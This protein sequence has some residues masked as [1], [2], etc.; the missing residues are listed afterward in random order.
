[1]KFSLFL[2]ILALAMCSV[3]Q[4]APKSVF[5][6]VIVGTWQDFTPDLWVKHMTLA[7]DAGI[8]GFVLNTAP[9]TE[10]GSACFSGRIKQQIGYA[11][12]ATQQLSGKST[13]K[14]FIAFDYLG[15]GKPWDASSVKQVLTTYAN[16]P[17]YF[18]YNNKAYVSTFEGTANIND[19]PGIKSAIT[20]GVFF[21]P[22]WTSLG[23]AGFASHL[24]VI[25]GAFSWDMWPN[26]AQDMTT[27]S[28]TAWKKA[29]GKKHYMMGI[30]PWFYTKMPAYN[31]AWVWRGD[32]MWHSR[33]DQI[34]QVQPDLVQIVTWND[35]GESHY[36]G[37]IFEPGVPQGAGTDA[38]AYVEDMPHDS[39]RNLLPYYIARYK[40]GAEPAVPTDKLQYWY[41]LTPSSVGNA[42]G[43]TGNN[44]QYQTVVNPNTVV[45]DK[46]F[47]TALVSAPAN[48]T[49]QI[50]NNTKTT[51]KAPKAGANHFSVP[52]NGQTGDVEIKIVC[53]GETLV[54]GTGEPIT[55]T[56]G[57]NGATNY[58]AWVGG[59]T[60]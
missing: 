34:S 31:K 52:F 39:W 22:D 2:S 38:E 23:P 53:N 7:R 33:W 16:H 43:V 28:D 27:D 36:I 48:V 10:P 1:M 9:N 41:R 12:D 51:F 17:G 58:N 6:H 15:G 14:L 25:D 37:P 24:D 50:G 30:S 49:V 45:Q 35:Y 8:D 11:F 56:P 3:A 54:E 60:A 20:G 18:R 44:G 26:G 47:V 21:V 42:D 57:E 29:L 4:G 55:H 40:K 46:V 19:W 5:A 32:D 59:A 13:F